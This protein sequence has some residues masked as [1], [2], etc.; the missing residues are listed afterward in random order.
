LPGEIYSLFYF[1]D[2]MIMMWIAQKSVE[3]CY[4]SSKAF[5]V[6]EKDIQYS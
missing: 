4:A 2:V 5:G 6:T 3:R 1:E